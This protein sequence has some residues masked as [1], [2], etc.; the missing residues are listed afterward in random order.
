MITDALLGVLLSGMEFIVSLL[1][2]GDPIGLAG[3]DGIWR[4]YAQ[5]NTFLPLTEILVAIGI[6]VTVHAGI[7]A[8]S[9]VRTVRDWLPFV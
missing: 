3:A 8:Y 5:F 2:T 6:I 9:A 4:G 7:L 1:P